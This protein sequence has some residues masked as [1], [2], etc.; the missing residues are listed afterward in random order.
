MASTDLITVG[1]GGSTA[2]PIAYLVTYGLGD[3]GGVTPAPTPS[4]GG[5]PHD[6]I[7]FQLFGRE[8]EWLFR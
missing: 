5:T 6:I 1:I 4:K 3:F 8:T 2:A 7:F